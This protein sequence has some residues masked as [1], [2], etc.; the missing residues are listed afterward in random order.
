ME[1]EFDTHKKS[2]TGVPKKNTFRMQIYR[3]RKEGGGA[4]W[5]ACR[6]SQAFYRE[7]KPKKK[8]QKRTSSDVSSA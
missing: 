7:E 2:P 6:R 5:S 8:E 4:S 3:E 1:T